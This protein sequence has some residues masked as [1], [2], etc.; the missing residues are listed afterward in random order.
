MKTSDVYRFVNVAP[1][2][3]ALICT[4]VFETRAAA[5]SGMGGCGVGGAGGLG[6]LGSGSGPGL[7]GSG[8]T[9]I[10]GPRGANSDLVDRILGLGT[11]GFDPS[12]AT[13]DPMEGS[14]RRSKDKPRGL[15]A[16]VLWEE[17][18]P[19]KGAPCRSQ[20]L[21][22]GY[23][24]GHVT[25]IPPGDFRA[26]WPGV[27]SGSPRETPQAADTILRNAIWAVLCDALREGKLSKYK[28]TVADAGGPTAAN[29]IEVITVWETL[30]F[31]NQA[32]ALTLYWRV[33]VRLEATRSGY[34][35]LRT[36][37]ELVG[38]H[39]GGSKKNALH[40]KEQEVAKYLTSAERDRFSSLEEAVHEEC[41]HR[42]TLRQGTRAQVD[43]KNER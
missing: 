35:K 4:P 9:E 15:K 20:K 42:L 18:F 8:Y 14:W 43:S 38:E 10:F 34:W 11:R 3:L 17:L 7:G 6:G 21:P 36:Q 24:R 16:H 13:A 5:Q 22:P 26:E 12:D 27:H 32:P 1:L 29:R 23:D 28:L 41:R 39:A 37:V 2:L 40:F 19:D 33:N 31:V 25:V 30:K